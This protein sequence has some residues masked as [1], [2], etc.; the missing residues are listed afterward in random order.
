MEE[1]QLA[2]ALAYT[3]PADETQ[4]SFA[5]AASWTAMQAEAAANGGTVFLG[6]PAHQTNGIRISLPT[7]PLGG[8]GIRR[9]QCYVLY[10]LCSTRAAYTA[11]IH[12]PLVFA[13]L[14]IFNMC[15][16]ALGNANEM[17]RRI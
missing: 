6:Y 14:R 11:A 10:L 15:L 3:Q 8:P 5:N 4:L 13:R 17:I 16:H 1:A 9:R 12:P 2:A 7:L